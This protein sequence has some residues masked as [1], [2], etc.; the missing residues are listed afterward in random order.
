[1]PI[2]LALVLGSCSDQDIAEEHLKVPIAVIA[3]TDVQEA[4]IGDKIRYTVTI[5]SDPELDVRIPQFG[6]NLDEFGIKEFGKLP[7]KKVK[8]K[9]ITKQWYLLDAYV[10]GIYTIPAPVVKFTEHDGKEHEVEGN[11]VSVEVKSVIADSLHGPYLGINDAL[12]LFGKL[13]RG[14]IREVDRRPGGNHREY[15]Y[16]I[17]GLSF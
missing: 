17:L 3:S 12:G 4:T 13:G 10:T 16:P 8:G 15:G 7:P 1:L 14:R 5:I 6:E 2:A 9:I 11:Q